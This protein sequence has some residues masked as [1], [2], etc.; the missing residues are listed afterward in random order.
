MKALSHPC[1]DAYIYLPAPSDWPVP[2]QGKDSLVQE[3]WQ[4][5]P[6][7]NF[8]G[9]ACRR[10]SGARQELTLLGVESNQL[11]NS[12]KAQGGNTRMYWGQDKEPRP[13]VDGKMSRKLC[14]KAC[15][16]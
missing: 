12:D 4:M 11:Q 3:K 15:N 10:A 6:I 5:I 2:E 14:V 9:P 8:W 16:T 7:D 1:L 13:S